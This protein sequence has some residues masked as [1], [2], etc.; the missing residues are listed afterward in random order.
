VYGYDQR[1]EVLGSKGA[2]QA[3]NP[4][5]SAMALWNTTGFVSQNPYPFFP[6]RYVE[7]YAAEMNHFI[8]AVADGKQPEVGGEAGRGSLALADAAQRSADTKAPVLL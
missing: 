3:G 4:T 2:L 6:E 5:A 1:V 7:A 8:D